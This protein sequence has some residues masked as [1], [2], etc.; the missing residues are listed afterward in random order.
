MGL[1]SAQW[2][3]FDLIA[4]NAMCMFTSEIGGRIFGW[5]QDYGD[6]ADGRG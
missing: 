3:R 1:A 2:A 6:S 5:G 4:L